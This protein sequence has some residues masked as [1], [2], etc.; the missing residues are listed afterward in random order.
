MLVWGQRAYEKPLYLY[1]LIV[2]NLKLLKKKKSLKQKE[3]VGFQSI[4]D[5]SHKECIPSPRQHKVLRAG[6][7]IHTASKN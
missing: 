4:V 6:Y 1:F 3:L 7:F 5:I 2:V